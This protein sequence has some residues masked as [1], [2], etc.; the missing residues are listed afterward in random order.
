MQRA[1]Q[2]AASR[3][4]LVAVGRELFGSVGFDETTVAEVLRRAGMA[5]G[6]LY[7][8]FP[9][10]KADLF[11]AVFDELNAELH[12]SRDTARREPSV[13]TRVLVGARAFLEL[14]SRAEFAR[15]V[16]VDA[17]RLI[18]GQVLPGSTFRVLHQEIADGIVDGEIRGNLDAPT[19]AH[20]LYGAIRGAGGHVAAA[21]DKKNAIT[22]CLDGIARI[23]QSLIATT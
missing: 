7:H 6:A 2:A 5:R 1:E 23:T 3:A 16:L 22:M 13:V 4:K 21:P 17:P 11:R 14:C 19:I 18:P 20:L 8:Y 12:A 15:V 9:D 10:G